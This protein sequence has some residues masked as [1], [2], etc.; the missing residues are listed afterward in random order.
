MMDFKVQIE[1]LEG[2]CNWSKWKRQIELLLKHHDV[3]DVVMGKLVKPN[4]SSSGDT[5]GSA[6][7]KVFQK[8]DAL[9]QLILVSSL[10]N[11]NI[12]LTATCESAKAIWDKLISVY[13]QSSGQR[14]D[15]LMEQF[16][17]IE[18]ELT[19]DIAT[20]ISKLQLIFSE[21]N[22]ELKRL[23]KVELP[24]LLLM[25][26]IMST[27]PSEYFEFKSVWESV[28][29]EERTVNKLTERL[30]LIEMRLPEKHTDSTA[31][32]AKAVKKERQKKSENRKCYKCHQVGHFAKLCPLKVNTSNSDKSKKG[33]SPDGEAFITTVNDI[34]KSD[35]WLA[36][37]GASA[38]MTYNKDFF[39]NYEDFFIPQNVYIGN[40]DII[41]A[42]GKGTINV[43]MK[44]GGKWVQNYLENV[45]YVP[46]ISRNLFS[47]GQ[48]MEKG[49]VFEANRR[50]CV[51]KKDGIVRLIGNRNTKGLF[52][53]E[54]CV[55]LPNYVAQV[56]SAT[57][58]ETVQLWHERLCHQNKKHV[59]N[60]LKSRGVDVEITEEFCDGCMFGKQ[61]RASFTLR[62]N[63][64]NKPG[65]LIHADL[66]GP[67]Q[68]NSV[69]GAKFFICFKDDYSKFRRV[70]FIKHKNEV[71]NCLRIF[72][73]EA[74]TKGHVIKE[75]LCDRGREFDNVE[76]KKI[77]ELRGITFRMTMPYTPQQNG[78]AERENRTLVEC[79]RSMIY[80]K[81]LPI[82]LWAEAIN[83]VVYILNRSGSTPVE[84]KVP[85]EVWCGKEGVNLDHIRVF[86]TKCYVHVPKQKRQKWD[87]KSN[88][89]YLVGYCSDMAGYR[90]WLKNENKVI[91]SRDVVFQ[92]ESVIRMTVEMSVN[93]DKIGC[94][95]TEDRAT[96]TDKSDLDESSEEATENTLKHEELS[97]RQVKK[98][99][100]LNDY[101]FFAEGCTAPETYSS[102]M[103]SD[104]AQQWKD[105]M[106]EE[107]SSL[108]ENDTWDLVSLPPGKKTIGNRWILRVKIKKDGSVHRYKAR[109][110]AKGCSQKWGID[111]EET[112]SPVARFDTVRTLISVA[113]SERLKLLQFDVRTA[114]LYGT[115]EEEVYMCQPEGYDDKSGRVCKLKRS[116]YGLKQAPRCWTKRF[117]EFMINQG[118]VRS[119]ADP[120]LFVLKNNGQ[121]L[122]VAVYVDDG[123]VAGTNINEMESFVQKLKTE[124]KITVG[125]VDYFL[126][127]EV[128]F[129]H[130]SSS[131]FICQSAYINR[132]LQK[133]GM[134][135][136]NTVTT[137]YEQFHTGDEDKI[138]EDTV[139]YREA[140]GSLMYLSVATRPDIAYAVSMVSE[141][142]EMP[143]L[144]NWRAVKRIFRYLK[145]TVDH[146]LLYTTGYKNGILEAFSDADYAGD[147]STRRSRTGVV[148][149][150]SGGAISWMSQKQKSVALSTTEAEYVA[151]S[152]GVK[153]IIWLKRLFSEVT[154]LREVP[155][156]LVDNAS[157]VK[158]IKN[159]EFHKRSK[160]IDIKYHFIREKYGSGDISIDHVDGKYQV[161]D[162]LTKPLSRDRY[163]MLRNMIGVCKLINKEET[164][165]RKC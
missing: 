79:A 147:V 159:P 98:P 109:L 119:S 65:E 137:P 153:D 117:G 107:M 156:L 88:I 110:V 56:Y 12:D 129:S 43:R 7:L 115:L 3:Y 116:L 13:E 9:A 59:Q 144:S 118:F 71:A 75:F 50:V 122:I 27:L 157:A 21:L 81:D 46:E 63:R 96:N 23:A 126:G 38:H 99:K 11:A 35:G 68:E 72:L 130:D 58:A 163:E 2:T 29:L 136:S 150:F 105:A 127:M 121:K 31:L 1:K 162:I 51:F 20:H 64:A 143:K 32:V 131:I 70:F 8:C 104:K 10:G 54:M 77:L 18:K 134:E 142:L 138:L 135:N 5:T 61:H 113:A 87:K 85:M 120:C 49:F 69:G 94:R 30:R 112:F 108:A 33:F 106:D 151:A 47:I 90:I 74:N 4:A 103:M 34:Q 28:P 97:R 19:N 91:L 15:R 6:E 60:F 165:E 148:C 128:T 152:E 26:R 41:K 22:D 84:N 42:Y 89:G 39:D 102:A 92:K 16:F 40:N 140:V 52:V 36:D 146:G 95:I 132:I 100:Y 24:D 155:T 67:M 124:F 83:T 76:V 78:S 111:Y 57:A 80:A 14:M 158:L 48:A 62:S 161:A 125:Y 160:H 154:T 145:G 133:F 149:K 45:W 101:V 73:N 123:L 66:C 37:S 55:C 44:I 141:S 114:F 53:L 86:G 139:P 164:F 25:S 17:T 82:K 93:T